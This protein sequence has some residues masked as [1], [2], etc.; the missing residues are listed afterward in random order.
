LCDLFINFLNISLT[1]LDCLLV[2]L[3]S[4]HDYHLFFVIRVLFFREYCLS[5]APHGENKTSSTANSEQKEEDPNT[6]QPYCYHYVQPHCFLDCIICVCHLQILVPKVSIYSNFWSK[7]CCYLFDYSNYV[8]SL[9][10]CF[11]M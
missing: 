3:D 1:H 10:Y 2:T 11:S 9:A 5:E 7:I 6:N 4:V 8:N